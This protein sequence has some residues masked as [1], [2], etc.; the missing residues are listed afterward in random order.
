MTEGK[1]KEIDSIWMDTLLG[2]FC[3]ASAHGQKEK[4]DKIWQKIFNLGYISFQ[5]YD[6]EIAL[7]IAKKLSSLQEFDGYLSMLEKEDEPLVGFIVESG[8]LYDSLMKH[9]GI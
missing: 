8:I 2:E 9:F 7:K 1:K 6:K 5:T 3:A 4:A